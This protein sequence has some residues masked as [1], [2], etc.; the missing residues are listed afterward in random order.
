[1]RRLN[2]NVRDGLALVLALVLSVVLTVGGL[3]VSLKATI[4]FENFIIE[5]IE[6]VDYAFYVQ[7][8]FLEVVESKA[9]L[10]GVDVD[11][12]NEPFTQ[13]K[14]KEDIFRSTR[15]LFDKQT[16]D[17]FV[18]ELTDDIK[19]HLIDYA[20]D[21]NITLTYDIEAGIDELTQ[22]LV[23]DYSRIMQVP[24]FKNFVEVKE[25]F[26][27]VFWFAFSGLLVFAGVI[28]LMLWKLYQNKHRGLRM[29]S[30]ATSAAGVMSL[31]LLVPLYVSRFYERIQIRP[32][33][34]NLLLAEIIESALGVSILI[35]IG[36]FV[37]SGV[38]IYTSEQKRSLIKK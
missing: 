6:D 22:D 30:Y 15:L 12:L 10:Y 18:D 13:E 5:Q 23:K 26:D 38:L 11:Y 35:A 9:I 4:F 2:T 1:M 7:E 27:R 19:A 34:F 28:L 31:I 24:L 37:I 3:L 16:P 21:Q 25:T 17:F 33:F 8:Y 14:M 20:N 32:R 29:I 36:W